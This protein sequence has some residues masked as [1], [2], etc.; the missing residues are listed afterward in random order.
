MTLADERATSA[1]VAGFAEAIA[2]NCC[3]AAAAAAAAA[4]EADDAVAEF[5]AE[6]GKDD[7][8]VITSRT[9]AKHDA[10]D[11]A[12]IPSDFIFDRSCGPH[13]DHNCTTSEAVMPSSTSISA[14]HAACTSAAAA[15]CETSLV[16][17]SHK[18]TCRR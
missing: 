12:D 14:S 5:A 7:R 16:T 6:S 8:R 4:D 3:N 2:R 18:S 11:T 15:I 1:A 9:T 17:Q 10:A 13:V